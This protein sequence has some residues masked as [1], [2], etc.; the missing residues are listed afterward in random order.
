MRGYEYQLDH[1][2]DAELSR[3]PWRLRRAPVRKPVGAPSWIRTAADS[4]VVNRFGRARRVEESQARAFERPP[5]IHPDASRPTRRM[6]FDQLR[7][8]VIA[9][10][11]DR[12]E[13]RAGARDRA[14][15]EDDDPAAEFE[16]QPTTYRPTRRARATTLD[17]VIESLLRGN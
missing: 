15:T 17:D 6:P 11:E 13:A 14:G 4:L 16:T 12:D 9:V 1:A 8:L 10:I 7:T 5:S 2:A 3:A